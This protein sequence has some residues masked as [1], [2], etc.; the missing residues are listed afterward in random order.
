[1]LYKWGK[2]L[3]SSPNLPSA[4]ISQFSQIDET[5]VFFSS[6]SDKGLNFV[7]QLFDRD[8]KLKTCESLKDELSLTNSKKFKLFQIIHVLPKQWREIIATYG[9]NL[10]NFFCQTIVSFKKI[11]FT[12][13]LSSERKKFLR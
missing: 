3:S 11:K 13:S 2:F 1:M 7:G 10:S 6:L 4:I 12:P 9:G 5:N 8:E